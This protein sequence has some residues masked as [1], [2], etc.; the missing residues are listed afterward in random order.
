MTAHETLKYLI[1]TYTGSHGLHAREALLGF[2]ASDHKR[3]EGEHVINGVRWIVQPSHTPHGTR[4]TSFHRV[5]IEC[6]V[7]SKVVSAGRLYQ[8]G[9]ACLKNTP[10]N[11]EQVPDE[12]EAFARI[13]MEEALEVLDTCAAELTFLVMP[14][15]ELQRAWDA[16]RDTFGDYACESSDGETWQYMGTFSGKHEF[17]HR[18][19]KGARKLFHVEQAPPA[20]ALG[21]SAFEPM[22]WTRLVAKHC[23]A[24]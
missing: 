11:A 13:P 6:P 20:P 21:T 7:C 2:K 19:Y 8:H 18:N 22:T 9:K 16:V 5:L 15:P 1:A 12:R 10:A 14:N 3:P 17:R 24:K 23:Q 4:K